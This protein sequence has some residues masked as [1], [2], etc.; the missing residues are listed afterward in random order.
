MKYLIYAGWLNPNQLIGYLFID[1]ENGN[2]ISSFEYDQEWLKNN[3]IVLDPEI[4]LYPGRQYSDKGLFG[5]LKDISPDRWGRTL[6]DRAEIQIA[7][8]E[9]RRPRTLDDSDYLLGIS[10]KLRSGGIRIASEGNNYISNNDFT[11]PPISSLRAI[12]DISYKFENSISEIQD[13]TLK[14]LLNSGSSLGGARPKA[15]VVDE[16]GEYWI[17]KFPSKNDEYDVEAFEA[18]SL[19]LASLCEINVPP[20]RLEKFNKRGS[21]LLVKRF[22]R[23]GD[24]RIHFASAM[25]LLSK[26]D[27]ENA[28]YLDIADAI[29]KYSNNTKEDLKELYKRMVFNICISNTDDHLRNHGFL[30]ND[31][32]WR[33]SPVFDIN[34]SIYGDSL[35]LSIDGFNSE[36]S[37]D[38]T[39]SVANIFMLS[40][41]EASRIIDT[42]KNTVQNNWIKLT[43]KYNI[44]GDDMKRLSSAFNQ[45]MEKKV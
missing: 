7:N 31:R 14:M 34:P 39:L 37:L 1:K 30:L 38:R 24:E 32:Y 21:T 22:D 5:F 10:D 35:S 19:D 36:M 20:F 29:A 18:L 13:E 8:K 9:N 6:L 44:S 33:L 27:G 45:Y 41:E 43:K 2:T 4:E 42:I 26:N 25:N 15:N 3:S 23:I 17:A 40:N 28:S 12:E 11:I 16:K